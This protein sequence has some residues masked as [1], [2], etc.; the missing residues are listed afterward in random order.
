M[1]SEILQKIS[2]SEDK[3]VFLDRDGTV[4]VDPPD[5]RVDKIEKIE[6]FPDSIGAL[7]YLADN[8]FSVIF[9]TNQAGIAEGRLNTEEF[10]KRFNPTVLMKN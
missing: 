1:N 8:N 10:N 3:I 7:K 2:K 4:I 6:L 9:I 5:L